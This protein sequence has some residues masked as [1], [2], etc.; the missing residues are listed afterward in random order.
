MYMPEWIFF[1]WK[2]EF[3]LFRKWS[4]CDQMQYYTFCYKKVGYLCSV[5]GL[6]SGQLL[7]LPGMGDCKNM[8]SEVD[9]FFQ[10]WGNFVR[11]K[12]PGQ[13][14]NQNITYSHGSPWVPSMINCAA[15][16]SQFIAS[17]KPHPYPGAIVN[18]LTY[19]PGR[20]GIDPWGRPMTCLQAR[21][22]NENYLT[23]HAVWLFWILHSS[24][25]N[26]ANCLTKSTCAQFAVMLKEKKWNIHVNCRIGTQN[27]HTCTYSH[28]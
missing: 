17:A 26:V 16:W 22:R 7:G 1:T 13:I 2:S 14:S 24:L 10:G 20:P 21:P 23:K 19:S 8:Q 9:N 4:H 28:M 3:I 25:A 18:S 15:S 5:V 27:A 12:C 6:P 11:A